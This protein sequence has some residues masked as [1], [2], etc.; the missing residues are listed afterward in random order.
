MIGDEVQSTTRLNQLYSLGSRRSFHAQEV[1]FR[2]GDPGTTMLWVLSGTVGVLKENIEISRAGRGEFIGEMSLIDESP[3]SAT[4]I[5]EGDCE[6][7][8]FNSQQFLALVREEPEFALAIMRNLS[9]KL[10]ESDTSRV[11]ELEESNLQLQAKN[12]QLFLANAF[13]EKIIEQS[14]AG[15]SLID[16]QAHTLRINP[17]GRRI[18][19]IKG[20]EVPQALAD[21]CVT[22]GPLFNLRLSGQDTWAGECK[23]ALNDGLKTL[24][25]SISPL[26]SET[27]QLIYL[28]IYED[29]SQLIELNEQIIKLERLATEGELAGEIAH[30]INNYLAV[31]SGNLELLQHRLGK[32]ADDGLRRPLEAMSRGLEEISRFVDDLMG[33]HDHACELA[34]LNIEEVVRVMIRFLSPQKRFRKIKLSAQTAS[35]FPTR[36]QAN[37]AMMH[38][39]LLNLL[40]NAADALG[41]IEKPDKQIAVE[42]Q[43]DGGNQRA[44][45]RVSDNGPGV[46]AEHRDQLFHRRFTTKQAGHGIGLMTVKKIIDHHGGTIECQSPAGGGTIFTISLPL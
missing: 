44:L 18:L 7:L 2:E 40:I 9:R 4:V 5:A 28:M 26:G 46:P 25:V 42:L 43:R 1:I 15:I 14:P 29:I 16:D 41:T 22:E 11:A 27:D 34:P 36:V 3:R 39:V 31:L 23:V 37:E 19:N 35:D 32:S 21:H 45:I 10:R 8:E 38:Q 6:A 12:E 33:A 17:A 13:L 30:N 24:Y 20:S